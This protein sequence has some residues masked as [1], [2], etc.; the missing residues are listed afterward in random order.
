VTSI[1]ASRHTGLSSFEAKQLL[2]QNGPNE[3]PGSGRRNILHM[4]WAV[5]KQPML[6]LLL[7]AGAINFL[8]GE[9]LDGVILMSFVL[10]VIGISIYQESKTENALA[11]LRDLSSPRALVIRDGSPLRIPGREVVRGDI[12][13]LAEGDRIPADSVLIECTQLSV[14]ESALT[15]ES[16]PVRKVSGTDEILDMGAPGG[17]AT[18]W[19][20]SGTLVVKGQ[21]I[22]R[23]I[24]TGGQGELGRIGI[25]LDSIESVDTALQSEM[26]RLV[27]IIALL[28]GVAAVL[29]VAVYA[30]TRGDFIHA[31]QAGIATAMAMLPEELP[32]VF[33]VF[34]ALGAWRISQRNV[35]TRKPP[36][37]EAL[38]SV[39]VVCVDKTGTLTMNAMTVKELCVGTEHCI[40]NDRELPEIFREVVEFASLASP[41]EP[42]DPMDKAFRSLADTLP[43]TSRRARPH[44][45]LVREYALTDQVLA[46][47]DVWQADEEN[48]FVVAAKGAPE[49]ISSLC[50]LDHEAKAALENRVKEVTARGFRVIAIAKAEFDINSHLP[51]T[52]EAFDFNLIGIA[53][54]QDPVRPGVSAAVAECSKAGVRTVM[55]T[56]DYPGTALAI[57]REVGLDYQHGCITGQELQGMTDI[58]LARRI[59]Q[60]SVFARMIP[61]QKLQLIRA[62]KMNGEV[63]AMTGDGVN[64]APALRAADIGIAMGQMGTDVARE[65]SDLVLTDDDFTSIVGGI[66]Q[67]RGI[68]DNMR[69]AMAYVISVHVPIVGMALIPVFVSDWPL[70]LLPI[71]IALLQLIIDPA[72]SIVFEADQIDPEIMSQQPRTIGAPLFSRKTIVISALQGL[73]VLIAVAT[74]FLIEISQGKSDEEIRSATF[75]ALVLSNLMLLLINRSWRLS[76]FE[77]LRVR[78]NPTLKWII[79]AVGILLVVLLSV[80]VIQQALGFGQLTL[81]EW[82]LAFVASVVGVSWFEFYKFK[83]SARDSRH[84]L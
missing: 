12:V 30:T 57:A 21:G 26:N 7:G 72:C 74:V 81:A 45:K 69:K 58:E 60:V 29:V 35:L 20:F 73:G 78:K 25:A 38:G 39:T 59:G 61:E 55:I 9:P 31:L 68:F 51:E 15:G 32:V 5:I 82:G 75:A 36:V 6:L 62:L 71:Q 52:V 47:S 37:I 27:R 77:T 66:R 17:D 11:A 8:L 63:V 24:N 64:D 16:V 56:G 2:L 54:L 44:W 34:L 48:P 18:S 3:L 67:G 50:H 49:S 80:P 70:V 19:L 13:L 46:V 22:G 76:A 4:S 23:V 10:V 40:V 1:P 79:M 53:A 42:F 84:A 33:T 83:V 65:A 14:D 28:G 41:I 43:A